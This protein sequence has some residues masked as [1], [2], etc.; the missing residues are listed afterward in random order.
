MT[1]TTEITENVYDASG[2]PTEDLVQAQDATTQAVKVTSCL[3][4]HNG[5]AT[6]TMNVDVDVNANPPQVRGGQI[7][8]GICGAPWAIT[9]GTMGANLVLTARRQGS[10]Q[11]ATTI[12]IVGNFANPP[13]WV[14]TY[15]FDGNSTA[16]RH[17]TVFNGWRPC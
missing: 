7:T 6:F 4:L 13:R 10:G 8:S 14:G 16:F 5:A 1:Q 11:C 17:T 2:G 9:G 3:V 12:T 15:G